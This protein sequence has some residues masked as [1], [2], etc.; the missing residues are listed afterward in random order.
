[1]SLVEAAAQEWWLCISS[2]SSAVGIAT[3]I[4]NLRL[5]TIIMLLF[6]CVGTRRCYSAAVEGA[7]DVPEQQAC[8]LEDDSRPRLSSANVKSGLLP[9]FRV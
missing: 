2:S 8:L 6:G 9:A 1:M 5:S 7:C 3:T 4:A